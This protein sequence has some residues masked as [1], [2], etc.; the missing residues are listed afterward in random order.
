MCSLCLSEGMT[1]R[2][3]GVNHVTSRTST[4]LLAIPMLYQHAKFNFQFS[5]S[6]PRTHGPIGL[7][8]GDDS[9]ARSIPSS[10]VLCHASTMTGR[11]CCRKS[12][13]GV[14]DASLKAVL[15]QFLETSDLSTR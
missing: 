9:H 13:S 6:S 1:G 8:L 10:H 5:L 3:S 7:H 12:R 4:P 11:L 14:R 2:P 15:V